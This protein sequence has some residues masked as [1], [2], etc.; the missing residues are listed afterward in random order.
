MLYAVELGRIVQVGI[1]VVALGLWSLH[2]LRNEGTWKHGMLAGLVVGLAGSW[3]LYWGYGLVL[4]AILLC[5]WRRA[6]T[7]LAGG[8]SLEWVRWYSFGTCR[9]YTSTT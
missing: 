6:L 5:P 8:Y 9:I 4:C 7:K 1:G 3:Y 2:Q